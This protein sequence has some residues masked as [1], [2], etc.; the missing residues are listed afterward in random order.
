M[1]HTTSVCHVF[2]MNASFTVISDDAFIHIELNA[3]VDNAFIFDMNA[4][5]ISND[6]F[7]HIELNDI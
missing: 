2:D 3:T 5:F 6:T 4:S 7:V 1:R